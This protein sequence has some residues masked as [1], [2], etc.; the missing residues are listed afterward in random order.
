M[1]LHLAASQGVGPLVAAMT[2]SGAQ[3]SCQPQHSQDVAN[4][5]S[6]SYLG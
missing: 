2:A 3:A 1:R 5:A 4:T 6:W